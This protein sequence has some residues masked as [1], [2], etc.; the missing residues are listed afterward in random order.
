MPV[1]KPLFSVLI[2]STGNYIG[3]TGVTSLSN[4]LKINT[5]LIKLNLDRNKKETTFI[6]AISKQLIL[7]HLSN[8]QATRSATSESQH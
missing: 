5:T 7:F 1:N 4:A 2:K 8:Q 6:N 3:Y